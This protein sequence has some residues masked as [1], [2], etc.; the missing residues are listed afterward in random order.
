MIR[1]QERSRVY[2]ELYEDVNEER[3][4][5]SERMQKFAGFIREER[6]AGSEEKSEHIPVGKQY[7]PWRQAQRILQ[8]KLVQA[9][10]TQKEKHWVDKGGVNES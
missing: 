7:V 1:E 5:L 3:K 2:K 10:T 9:E 8:A 6:S 4:M